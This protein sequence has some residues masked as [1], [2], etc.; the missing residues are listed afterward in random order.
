MTEKMPGWGQEEEGPQRRPLRGGQGQA[1]WA[2]GLV[3]AEMESAGLLG[4]KGVTC[5]DVGCGQGGGRE[6]RGSPGRVR[7]HGEA[8]GS[9]TGQ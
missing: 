8:D 3:A 5:V 6:P 1:L 7:G 9:E 4:A 2:G